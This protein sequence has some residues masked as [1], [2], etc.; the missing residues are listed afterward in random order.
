MSS[1]KDQIVLSYE[2]TLLRESDFKLL[3]K[4][5]WLNDKIISFWF[6]YLTNTFVPRKDKLYLCVSPEI[7]QLI[8]SAENS[9]AMFEELKAILSDTYYS[10]KNVLFIPI[11][12]S[13]YKNYRI[14]GKLLF[15]FSCI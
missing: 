7:T 5:N 13:D 6:S 10:S 3:D 14:G 12:D 1:K 9:D 15:E 4:G 8:K 2:D 11:N